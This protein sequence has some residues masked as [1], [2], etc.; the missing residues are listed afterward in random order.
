MGKQMVWEEI[1]RKAAEILDASD[2]IWGCAETAFAEEKSVKVLCDLLRKEGFEVEEGL[3]GVATA[4]KGTFG[5]GKPVIGFLGEFDALSGLDQEAGA[6]EKKHM[7][8]EFS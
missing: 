8:F 7:E 2:E 1:D 4:F 3:A 6:T 5:S